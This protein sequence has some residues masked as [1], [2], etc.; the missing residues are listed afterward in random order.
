MLRTALQL[1]KT[2]IINRSENNEREQKQ[3]L[4]RGRDVVVTTEVGAL[5]SSTARWS[6][7]DERWISEPQPPYVCNKNERILYLPILPRASH[8]EKPGGVDTPAITRYGFNYLMICQLLFRVRRS[9]EGSC[10]GKRRHD[11]DDDTVNRTKTDGYLLVFLMAIPTLF[12]G[13]K[14]GER[15]S[16]FS[17]I[18]SCLPKSILPPICHSHLSKLCSHIGPH[19]AGWRLQHTPREVASNCFTCTRTP[20]SRWL[21]F[22]RCYPGQDD[23]MDGVFHK[24][25]WGAAVGDA[26]HA[27]HATW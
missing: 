18:R 20:N 24:L 15:K 4:H 16:Y 21:S 26:L 6:S 5:S 10:P 13:S 8:S 25:A 27:T 3:F 9:Y 14:S 7:I 2:R 12:H 23:D 1:S 22:P 19:V 17:S 11:D